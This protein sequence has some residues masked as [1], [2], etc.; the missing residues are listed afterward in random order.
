MPQLS[1]R[2]PYLGSFSVSLLNTSPSCFF[3]LLFIVSS[4]FIFFSLL[5]PCGVLHVNE[6][7][8]GPRSVSLVH[9]NVDR[10]PLWFS[11]SDHTFLQ[12][13]MFSTLYAT[14]A[15]M[16]QYYY[17]IYN[18]CTCS[19]SY[20]GLF[21]L[22]YHFY[23]HYYHNYHH[24]LFI[25]PV[26]MSIIYMYVFCIITVMH[27]MYNL[28]WYLFNVSAIDIFYVWISYGIHVLVHLSLFV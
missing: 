22:P 25:W 24:F 18:T 11:L 8:R 14:Y 4:L 7:G 21:C 3:S 6:L 12:L 28:I 15:S 13:Y 10:V 19:R 2:R 17:T 27:C 16:M 26:W 1:Y 5:Y 9:I 20:I 23:Y